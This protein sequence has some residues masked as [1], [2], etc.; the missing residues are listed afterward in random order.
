MKLLEFF[1]ATYKQVFGFEYPPV[2]DPAAIFYLLAPEAFTTVDV[3][4][5]I[6]C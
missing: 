4:V 6:E 5:E 1:A 3:I 2:H